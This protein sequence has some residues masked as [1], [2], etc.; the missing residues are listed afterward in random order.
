MIH[1]IRYVAITGIVLCTVSL[2]GQR[3][4]AP[5]K[6]SWGE[7]MVE[8]P[9]TLI[10]KSIAVNKQGFYMLRQKNEGALSNEQAYIEYYDSSMKLRKSQKLE[11]KYKGKLRDF[12]DVMMIGGQLYLF[13]SFNNQAK[14]KN[15]LFYQK[16]S[17]RLQ[18]SRDLVMVSEVDAQNKAKEGSFHLILSSD[19]SKV[20]LYSQLPYQKKDPERFAL[21]VFDNEMNKL[22]SHD[23]ILPYTDQQFAIEDYRIDKEGNVYIMGKLYLD[24]ARDSR[25]RRPNYQYVILAYTQQG[26][27]VQEYHVGLKEKFITDLAF[28][29]GND[30]NLVCAGFFSEKG[31]YSVKGTCFFRLNSSNKEVF[32]LSFREF[33]FK[34]RTEFMRPGELKRASRAEANDDTGRESELYRYSLDELVLRSDGGAVLVAEQYYVYERSYR[35]WDGTLR[36]EYYYNYNDIIVVNIQADGSIEW[37]TRIPKRQETVNDGGYYSSY[38]MSI[39]RDRLYFIFNDNSRNFKNDG[40]NR[41]YNF[42]GRNS[43]VALAELHKDGQLQMYPL[44]HNRDADVITRPKICKQVASRRMMVYGERGRQYRFAQIEFE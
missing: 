40:S 12:E 5:A 10:T 7:E 39:V 29:I 26:E 4:E 3:V 16:I 18:A 15:Y 37:A 21:K 24:G 25:R 11:L 28:R 30:G 20:L 44:F 34:F 32:N 9:G 22:W 13:T 6:I 43:I 19:S 42:S 17:K 23:I 41:L 2:W 35:Y 38:A 36:F 31:A 27:D 33:D 1:M 14:K 8:P